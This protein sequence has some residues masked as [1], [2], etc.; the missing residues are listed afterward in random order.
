MI[1]TLLQFYILVEELAE[2]LLFGLFVFCCF[3]QL[4]FDYL[5]L[6]CQRLL[7][8]DLCFHQSLKQSFVLAVVAHSD[9]LILRF[10]DFS[11]V[12]RTVIH[13][14]HAAFDFV[15]DG[16]E[17][18]CALAMELVIRLD[19]IRAIVQSIMDWLVGRS[20]NFFRFPILSSFL[21]EEISIE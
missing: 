1:Q 9:L 8:L 12:L 14:A 11:H 13:L 17:T 15:L 6:S 5:L 2:S 4:E 18:E 10:S 3:R 20:R 7:C 19:S 21:I 16:N